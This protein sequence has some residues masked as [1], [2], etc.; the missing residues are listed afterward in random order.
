M[1][2]H[3][4]RLTQG[5]RKEERLELI[6]GEKW[7]R[8]FRRRSCSLARRFW[9]FLAANWERRVM[10]CINNAFLSLENPNQAMQKGHFQ[11]DSVVGSPDKTNDDE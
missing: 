9:M 5:E 2:L 6:G 11:G 3:F 10:G 8:N 1:T 7:S 4:V